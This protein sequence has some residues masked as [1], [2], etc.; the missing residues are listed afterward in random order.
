MPEFKYTKTLRMTPSAGSKQMPK[1]IIEFIDKSKGAEETHAIE[2][3]YND[4][5]SFLCS[6]ALTRPDPTSFLLNLIRDNANKEELRIASVGLLG[7]LKA[8]DSGSTFT[9]VNLMYDT[10]ASKTLRETAVWALS[11]IKSEIAIAA[12]RTR[13]TNVETPQYERGWIVAAMAEMEET[14]KESLQ[15][16]LFTL[17]SCGSDWLARKNAIDAIGN[18]DKETAILAERILM[19]SLSDE[20]TEVK[21]SAIAALVKVGGTKAV[22]R[23]RKMQ[24]KD[25]SFKVQKSA[26]DALSMLDRRS[27][28]PSLSDGFDSTCSGHPSSTNE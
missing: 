7:E 9:L 6:T 22:G 18:L 8:Q 14:P 25:P 3:R 12:L 2:K 20:N 1:P 28:K 13:L 4:T 5:W 26:V 15:S 19:E 21:L 24:S 10:A 23:L 11:Q 16:L 17:K 27:G